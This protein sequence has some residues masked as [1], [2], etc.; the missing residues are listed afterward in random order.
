MTIDLDT[1]LVDL[2]S[3]MARADA[4]FDRLINEKFKPALARAIDEVASEF[5]AD[6]FPE[7]I[8]TPATQQQHLH[9]A[10]LARYGSPE[11]AAKWVAPE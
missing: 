8:E 1:I 5:L 11:A 3:R 4:N 9:T 7:L 6:N 2:E 10:A